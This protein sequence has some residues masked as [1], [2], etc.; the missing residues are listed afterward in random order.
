MNDTEVL[1]TFF[2]FE[3]SMQQ[4]TVYVLLCIFL[5]TSSAIYYAY[6]TSTGISN[7]VCSKLA[8]CGHF[9]HV[10]NNVAT[11]D[12]III[13]IS[14][15]NPSYDTYCNAMISANVTF[16]FDTAKMSTTDE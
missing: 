2:N 11:D 5:N 12:E 10:L 6:V 7:S 16:I 9:Q 1:K 4:F 13:S 14:G 15:I 3:L 8:P